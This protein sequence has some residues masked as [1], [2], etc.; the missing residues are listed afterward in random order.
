VR[1]DI[2]ERIKSKLQEQAELLATL[3]TTSLNFKT[4]LPM[5]IKYALNPEYPADYSYRYLQEEIIGSNELLTMDV[6]NRGNLTT[7]LNNI[8]TTETLIRINEDL[9][10]SHVHQEFIQKNGCPSVP[11]K[12]LGIKIG[13]CVI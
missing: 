6:H 11:A 3:R 9:E 13:N 8:N 1:K 2:P 5:Y 12:V 10:T 4:F 7:Y